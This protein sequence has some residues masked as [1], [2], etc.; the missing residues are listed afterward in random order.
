VH[1]SRSFFGF[2]T[3]GGISSSFRSLNGSCGGGFLRS[4]FLFDRGGSGSNLCGLG[5]FSSGSR[6]SRCGSSSLVSVDFSEVDSY[7]DDITLL[8]EVLSDYSRMGCENVDGDLIGLDA[9]N[10][11]IGC[12]KFSNVYETKHK[13]SMT[14]SLMESPMLGTCWTVPKKRA[15][16]LKFW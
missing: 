2:Y 13:D 10:N 16:L 12:G 15:L 3:G 14:P 5:G 1:S 6:S 7:L 9:R 8:G 4:G 11:L